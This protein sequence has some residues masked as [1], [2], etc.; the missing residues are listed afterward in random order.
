MKK[1]LFMVFVAALIGCG[2][3]AVEIIPM[4]DSTFSV[5]VED[6][7]GIDMMK[8]REI[9][10]VHA[11]EKT[12]ALGFSHFKIIDSWAETELQEYGAICLCT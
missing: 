3:T 4:K 11:A 9:A 6:D 7:S 10:M 12:I 2:T 5:V 1:I 8:I